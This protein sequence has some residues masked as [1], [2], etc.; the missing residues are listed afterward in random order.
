[1]EFP[2]FHTVPIA[3]CLFTG[4]LWEESGSDSLLLLVDIWVHWEDPLWA[5]SSVGWIFL[6]L[7][8]HQC[9]CIS[10]VLG[11]WKQDPALWVW[12]HQCWAEGKVHLPW[13]AGKVLYSA[14]QGPVGCLCCKGAL[15][16]HGQ[17]GVH[18]DPQ[19][20]LCRAAF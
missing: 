4:Y 6:G 15:L 9:D 18:Q 5:C 12:A 8:S 19:V 10:S 17:L 13:P 20:L 11:S 1:M 2:V 7:D 3:S 16:A 14:A